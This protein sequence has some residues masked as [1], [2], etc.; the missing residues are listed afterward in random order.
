MILSMLQR[1]KISLVDSSCL[2]NDTQRSFAM[3]IS[4]QKKSTRL[5]VPRMIMTVVLWK[6]K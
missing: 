4:S 1:V 3:A 6:Y 2:F 5:L